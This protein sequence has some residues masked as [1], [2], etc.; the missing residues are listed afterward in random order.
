[1]LHDV[2]HWEEH[3]RISRAWWEFKPIG[4]ASPQLS[5]YVA[6]EE[7]MPFGKSIGSKGPRLLKGKKISSH[8]CNQTEQSPQRGGHC[9]HLEANIRGKK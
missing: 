7:G 5:V 6:V 1:M 3:S 4:I 2:I 9:K 8:T